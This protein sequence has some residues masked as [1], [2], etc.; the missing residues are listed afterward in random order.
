MGRKFKSRTLP[1]KSNLRVEILRTVV[2]N[3]SYGM[4]SPYFRALAHGKLVGTHCAACKLTFLPP[5]PHCQRCWQNTEWVSVSRK[6]KVATFAVVE[7]PGQGFSEDLE[8]VGASL[9]SVI[10]YVAMP[11]VD[12]KLMSRLE[13]CDPADVFIGMSVEARF[14]ENPQMNALDVYFVPSK[15]RQAKGA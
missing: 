3:H 6:G 7:Y 9:P 2:H 11:G 10:I 8:A 13:E 14:V 4:T 5:R 12:T 1:D 15:R